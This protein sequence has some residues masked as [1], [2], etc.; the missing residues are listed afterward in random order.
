MNNVT[1]LRLKP[2]EDFIITPFIAD[3]TERAMS[4][5]EVG[6]PIHLSGP[7]GTGKTTLALHIASLLNRPVTLIH[8]DKL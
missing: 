7:A 4:Y 3:I 6:Y 2:K 1:V 8:G 5:L